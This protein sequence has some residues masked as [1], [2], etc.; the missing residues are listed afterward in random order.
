MI[1][2]LYSSEGAC[3]NNIDYYNLG[4]VDDN[5]NSLHLDTLTNGGGYTRNGYV[6]TS[7]M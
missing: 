5:A 7:T 4:D 2:F 6:K 3:E 1:Y